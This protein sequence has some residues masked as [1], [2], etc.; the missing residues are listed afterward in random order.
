MIDIYTKRDITKTSSE[1]IM[2]NAL[3]GTLQSRELID[4]TTNDRFGREI[5]AELVKFVDIIRVYMGL[6]T[7][8]NRPPP[9]LKNGITDADGKLYNIRPGGQP[10]LAHPDVK[11]LEI[12]ENTIDIQITARS[13]EEALNIVRGKLKKSNIL[14]DDATLLSALKR[15]VNQ[16]IRLNFPL[17]FGEPERRCLV[18]MLCNY[19]A[20]HNRELFLCEGFDGA[21]SYVLDG[22]TP[23]Q[24]TILPTDTI[25]TIFKHSGFSHIDHVLGYYQ[26]GADVF[27]VIIVY[28]CFQ[29]V[30][31][32]GSLP[33]QHPTI[34]PKTIRFD[35]VHHQQREDRDLGILH[36]LT[37]DT[38]RDDMKSWQK[39]IE[40]C[41]TGVFHFLSGETIKQVQEHMARDVTREAINKYPGEGCFTEET[42][43]YM[44]REISRRFVNLLYQNGYLETFIERVVLP[45]IASR[46]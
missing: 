5:D 28:G 32:L 34:Q 23:P 46:S 19:F 43:A 29:F 36:D 2:L 12:F 38:A 45:D 24:P 35:P 3:G 1:H 6:K 41:I 8:D 13:E 7:G 33:E 21:R 40:Q 26:D 22:C 25:D 10:Q 18:K 37:Y 9:T 11:K 14:I 42:C 27:G 16:N 4:K 44:A 15:T 31:R 39:H 30:A 17:N 20:M